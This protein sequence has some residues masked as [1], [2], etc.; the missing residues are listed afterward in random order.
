MAQN[1]CHILDH[2]PISLHLLYNREADSQADPIKFVVE[3]AMNTDP[4]PD[5]F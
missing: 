5:L 1:E 3:R 4:L 2:R